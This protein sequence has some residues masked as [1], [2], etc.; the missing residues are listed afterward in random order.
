[1]KRVDQEL[2]EHQDQHKNIIYSKTGDNFIYRKGKSFMLTGPKL[3]ELEGYV[4]TDR[5]SDTVIYTYHYPSFV[6]GSSI[7]NSLS[8]RLSRFF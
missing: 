5:Q 8:V 3:L 1:M 2:K 7:F 6:A 4:H